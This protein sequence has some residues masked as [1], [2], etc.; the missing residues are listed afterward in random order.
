[1]KR[2][3]IL[4]DNYKSA[5]IIEQAMYKINV[6]I[7]VYLIHDIKE[8]YAAVML[9]RIDVLIIDIVLDTKKPGDTSGVKFV[10]DIRKM[11]QYQFSPVIFVTSLEDPEFYAYRELHC[12][13]YIEKP[14]DVMQIQKLVKEA[15]CFQVP[16]IEE[17]VLY[18]RKD[19][20]LYPVNCKEVVFAESTNH[21]MCFHFANETELTIY[22]KTCKQLVEEAA[23]SDFVQCNKGTIINKNYVTNVDITNNVITMKEHIKINIG[24][25][26]K[27]M[28]I[29]AFKWY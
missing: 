22:Y 8:A 7:K 2:I 1:M 29:E 10:E 6:D 5:H 23:I 9:N 21:K 14:F 17:K 4:E 15:L 13:G 18:F 27:K 11:N 25:A 24:Q 12:Y 20:I 19:G 26:Y 28:I 16:D 3:L